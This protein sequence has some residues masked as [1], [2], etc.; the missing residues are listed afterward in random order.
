MLSPDLFQTVATCVGLFS[1][2]TG[3]TLM[4]TGWSR[5]EMKDSRAS[6]AAVAGVVRGEKR[7]ARGERR[8][9]RG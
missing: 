5:T 4:G 8:E 7:R 9:A 1:A 2:D 3:R 6:N